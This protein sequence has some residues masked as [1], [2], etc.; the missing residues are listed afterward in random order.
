[1]SRIVSVTHC[2]DRD[3]RRVRCE[4][5]S[6]RE[7]SE[8]LFF[9]K[10]DKDW[11]GSEMGVGGFQGNPMRIDTKSL[12]REQSLQAQN[13]QQYSQYCDQRNLYGSM[14][15][16]CSAAII[17]C[18]TISDFNKPGEVL[19]I[20][21]EI[22]EPS[23]DYKIV[24]PSKPKE[25]KKKM[26]DVDS[27]IFYTLYPIFM[28]L[29]HLSHMLNVGYFLIPFVFFAKE[30]SFGFISMFGLLAINSLFKKKEVKDEV[31]N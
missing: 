12:L 2:P 1:M 23:L 26:K 16:Q 25:K 24:E 8:Y 6:E 15:V 13:A 9:S 11:I 27:I 4:D 19:Y 30:I 29:L 17:T 22:T 10:P 31:I 5:G 7:I 18:S 20:P 3:V 14:G 21:A 28:F